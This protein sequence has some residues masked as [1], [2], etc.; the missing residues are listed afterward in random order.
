MGW[1]LGEWVG[2]SGLLENS[3]ER[4]KSDA[5]GE[6]IASF[7]ELHRLECLLIWYSLLL[8]ELD[9]CV[10]VLHACEGRDRLLHLLD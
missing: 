2:L 1:F 5:D 8:G 9:E 10:D 4:E 6:K 7:D 3:A